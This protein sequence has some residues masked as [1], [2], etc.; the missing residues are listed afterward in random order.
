VS[1]HD[2]PRLSELQVIS[3][4]LNSPNAYFQA[5]DTKFTDP[6]KRRYFLRIEEDLR[7]LDP[8]AWDALRNVAAQRLIRTKD[9]G[10][11]PLF[12]ALNEAKA[13]NHLV[14]IGCTS[15]KFIPRSKKQGGRTP[16]LQ[17]MSNS[18]L[19]FCEVKTINLS[20]VEI[21]RLRSSGIGT[22]LLEVEDGLLNKIT[23]DLH[24][25]HDQ[26]NKFYPANDARRIIYMI[27]NFDN[28]FDMAWKYQNQVRAHVDKVRPLGVE[29]VLFFK[30]PFER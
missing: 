16:D 9:R 28:N 18:V 14:S 23:S 4:R 12:D 20:A 3:V 19:T 25:A 7:S 6:L 30:P 1:E 11:Q 5:A 27:V 10:W 13:Y 21:E 17:A 8:D 29:V 15:V 2:F 22:T 26:M 24:N